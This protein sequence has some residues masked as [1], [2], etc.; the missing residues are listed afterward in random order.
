MFRIGVLKNFLSTRKDPFL[1]SN[2][3]ESVQI[4]TDHFSRELAEED[5]ES[6]H[7]WSLI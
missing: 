4:E 5:M 1:L 3:K 7:L 2:E 6:K